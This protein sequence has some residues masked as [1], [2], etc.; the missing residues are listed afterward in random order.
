MTGAGAIHGFV[1]TFKTSFVAFIVAVIG[2]LALAFVLAFVLAVIGA[3][4]PGVAATIFD[5]TVFCFKNACVVTGI[6]DAFTFIKTIIIT[7]FLA[8]LTPV[9]VAFIVAVLQD[10]KAISY[11]CCIEDATLI[12]T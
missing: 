12:K 11:A 3:F 10:V 4:Y 9:D 7:I 5:N 2:V 8:L 1:I 6:T